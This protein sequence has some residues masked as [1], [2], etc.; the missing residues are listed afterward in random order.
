[1][2]INGHRKHSLLRK[3]P[4]SFDEKKKNPY[5]IRQQIEYACKDKTEA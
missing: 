3:Y 2:C 1:M 5:K 4:Q